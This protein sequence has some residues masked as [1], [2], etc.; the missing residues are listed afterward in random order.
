MNEIKEIIND[1]EQ[2]VGRGRERTNS[3]NFA[4]N[5]INLAQNEIK[6]ELNKPSNQLVTSF[7]ENMV[8]THPASVN[9]SLNNKY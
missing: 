1:H 3:D 5:V 7:T 4:D 9:N 6:Q 2:I 8:Y